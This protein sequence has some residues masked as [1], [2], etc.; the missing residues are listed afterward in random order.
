MTSTSES[1]GENVG[2]VVVA[3]N[4]NGVESAGL[5]VVTKEVEARGTRALN[6]RPR[7]GFSENP[8]EPW[9]N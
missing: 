3:V 9:T 2:K 5:Y 6:K 8:S 4:V 7:V 1:L